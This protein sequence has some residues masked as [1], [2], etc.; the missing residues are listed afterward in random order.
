MNRIPHPP[1]P[2]VQQF[3]NDHCPQAGTVS[4]GFLQVSAVLRIRVERF[5]NGTF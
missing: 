1:Q 4:I 3:R 2:E 5:M